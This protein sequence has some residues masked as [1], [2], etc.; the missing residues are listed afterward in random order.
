M[1]FNA[2]LESNP[3]TPVRLNPDTPLKLE[4]IIA[5]AVEKD[6][7]VRYQHASDI[8]SDLKRLKRDT[9]TGKSVAKA[10]PTLHWSRR[11][12]V[13]TATLCIFGVALVGAAVVYVGNRSHA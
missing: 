5:K 3:V 7:D 4:E 13:I 9:E 10:V 8:R 2:I 11:T 12:L 1:I 6:R